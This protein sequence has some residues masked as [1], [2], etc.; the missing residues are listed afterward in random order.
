MDM[1]VRLPV[2]IR[3][4]VRLASGECSVKP[5]RL[6]TANDLA[7]ALDRVAAEGTRRLTTVH[8]LAAAL[9]RVTQENARLVQVCEALVADRDAEALAEREKI[10]AWLQLQGTEDSLTPERD[11]LD[12]TNE[13]L[14][15]VVVAITN[16]AHVRQS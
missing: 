9:D 16:G 14:T 6:T 12:I 2:P 1:P 8:H 11:Y 10:V 7:A 4:A 15:E 13:V 5:R 3:R